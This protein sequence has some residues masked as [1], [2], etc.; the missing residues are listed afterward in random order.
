MNRV[1]GADDA[2]QGY[3]DVLSLPFDQMAVNFPG[4]NFMKNMILT[5]IETFNQTV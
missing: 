2:V 1:T 3:Y 5:T 4:R